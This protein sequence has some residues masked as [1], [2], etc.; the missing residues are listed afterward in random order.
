MRLLIGA[1]TA[2][3]LTAVACSDP[4]TCNLS[5][6]FGV[7][8]LV[9]DS[10]SGGFA[11]SGARLLLR[12]GAYG[13]SMEVP[14]NR[15]DL[16]QAS[17]FGALERPGVYTVTVRKANYQD[18]MRTNVGVTAGG[19]HVH[20]ASLTARLQLPPT[21]T[22][23]LSYTSSPG[24]WVGAGETHQYS[25][26]D[27]RWAV[28]FDPN[29]AGAQHVTIAVDELPG[30]SWWSFDFAVPQGQW[31]TVGTY[32]G[33][34]RWPFQGSGQAGLA[35]FSNSRGCNELTGRFVVLAIILGPNNR[36]DQFNATFEQHCESAASPALTG[37]IAIAANPWH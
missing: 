22:T 29:L 4:S 17:L 31:L 19:C 30:G 37:E 33:A 26:A 15:P 34:I 11:A 32:E 36:L 10:A 35:V 20:P 12:D 2:F 21:A 6:A 23:F 18:W 1:L 13:D 27:G 14:S 5:A 16:D 24:D 7:N 25:L 28:Q 9:Q 8:V 3:S